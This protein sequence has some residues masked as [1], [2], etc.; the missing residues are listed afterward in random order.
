MTNYRCLV[1]G[2]YENGDVWSIDWC[3]RSNQP[4]S[5]LLTTWS[6]AWI[7]AWTDGTHGLQTL[8]HTDTS[9]QSFTVYQLNGI[10]EAVQRVDLNSVQLGTS[11]DTP[12]PNRNA[13]LI[14]KTTA[15]VGRTER[16]FTYLPA[17]VEGIVVNGSYTNT[18]MTRV[19][20]AVASVLTAIQSDGSALF[21][22]NR[23]T[24]KAGVPP[25]TVTIVTGLRVSEKASTQRRRT[26]PEVPVYV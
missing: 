15:L 1:K 22:Y 23:K 12:L 18:A 5:T 3:V 13:I 21:M 14:G 16:G 2:R 19:K 11:S 25:Y 8:Y 7:A 4:L 26:D 10:M 20:A 24:T 17:P 6:N 9:I